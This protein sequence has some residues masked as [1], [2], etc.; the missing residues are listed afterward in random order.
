[1]ISGSSCKL[2]R[3]RGC[4]WQIN[5]SIFKILLTE[6]PY[7]LTITWCISRSN[8]CRMVLQNRHIAIHTGQ[9]TIR[10]SPEKYSLCT[11]SQFLLFRRILDINTFVYIHFQKSM[12]SNLKN[13]HFLLFDYMCPIR[14]PQSSK[15]EIHASA[16][17]SKTGSGDNN[18]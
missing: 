12:Y 18:R 5:C 2:A 10:P 16:P 11:D 9:Y 4:L 8:F 13:D 7:S 3:F 17:S 15:S 1:M 6:F 14:F